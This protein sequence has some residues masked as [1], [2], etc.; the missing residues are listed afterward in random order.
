MPPAVSWDKM[1]LPGVLQRLGVTYFVVA[2]VELLFA[3]PVPERGAWVS[4][5][6]VFKRERVGNSTV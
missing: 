1:R 4:D 5:P 3:K 2:V 6:A